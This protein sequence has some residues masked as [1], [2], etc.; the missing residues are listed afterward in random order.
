MSIQ[1]FAEFGLSEA[2]LESLKKMG[3]EAPT[4]IQAQTIPLLLSGRDVLGQAQTG[5]GKTAA[6]AIPAIEI[7]D[8][9]LN[10]IQVLIQCPTRELAIQVTGEIQKLSGQTSGL[11]V[12]PV[13]GGQH[14]SHQIKAISRGAQILVGT[15]GRTIDHL[16]RGTLKLGHLKM[17]IFDE[18]DEMLNMGFREDME[19]ILT[20]KQKENRVQMLMFSATVP[21]PIREIMKRF[22][23]DPA[24]ITI[25]RS[26]VTTPDIKQFVVEVRDSVRVEA[27]CRLM[28]VNN[29]KLGL[30]FCN[31]KVATE[32]VSAELQ[33][34][35][36]SSEI[37]NGDLSQGQRDKVMQKF[38]SG[39]ID[40]LIATDVAARG[41]D[42]DDVDVVFNF[43]IPQDPE[44]YVHRIGRTGRAGKSGTA[45]TFASGR[46]IR[47]IKF[48]ERFTQSAIESVGMPSL[49]DV[50]ESR[51]TLQI[52][53]LSDVLTKGGLKPYIEQ[54]ESLS[55]LSYSPIEIA[56][57]FLKM[58]M[59]EFEKNRTDFPE[60][61]NFAPQQDFRDDKKFKKGKREKGGKK[62]RGGFVDSRDD[63]NMQTL[64]FNVGRSD[65][66]RPGD[67]VGAI[68]GE[69]GIP[70]Y[71]IGH[72]DIQSNF[73]F[74]DI[75]SDK[76]SLVMDKMNKARIRKK[77]VKVKPA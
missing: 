77:N 71:T 74:V 49:K 20:Y 67:I 34:R 56:A 6:F 24:S 68:A 44:Q 36:Y 8:P 11:R 55:E 16:K 10:Q 43:D 39:Q 52:N 62:D 17:V 29:Y 51:M 46:R 61:D 69:S 54:I 27:I 3:F 9:S 5:T 19:E 50:K 28:D 37:L 31:T 4:P 12:V 45:Y 30:I 60:Q 14:I 7:A 38:R 25:E 1:S 57:A 76:V 2:V 73:S 63:S 75:P 33:S 59:E 66:I 26:P 18:A 13:Y 23:V 32:N 58:R 21:K 70:G 48:I 40:L 42:V 22:M 64:R 72:I 41:I 53:E 65:N 35:G 47:S 15:P